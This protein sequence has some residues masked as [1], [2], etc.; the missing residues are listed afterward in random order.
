MC[1]ALKINIMSSITV[2]RTKFGHGNSSTQLPLQG[3]ISLNFNSFL[4]CGY[5]LGLFTML[6]LNY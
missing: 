3:D 1:A 5:L 4:F 6:M 2:P